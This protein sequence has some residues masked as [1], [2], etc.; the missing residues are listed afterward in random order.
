MYENRIQI[1]RDEKGDMIK[2]V[3]IPKNGELP[4][5]TRFVYAHKRSAG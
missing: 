1:Q 5:T 3:T 4:E 2:T